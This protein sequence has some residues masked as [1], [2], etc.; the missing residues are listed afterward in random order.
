MSRLAPA[1]ASLLIAAG[2]GIQASTYYVD[3]S[4]G[5]DGQDGLKPETAW[6]SLAK[7]NRAALAPG[8][9]VLFRR[10]QTWRGQLIP[11]SGEAGAVI[12]YG[13]F[14]EGD[15]PILLGSVAANRPEDW[16]QVGQDLWATVPLRFDPIGVH[17]DLQ[18]GS[19]SFYQEGGAS[20]AFTQ[21][22]DQSG[23]ILR[24]VCQNPGTRAHHMQLSVAGLK[25]QEGE[26]YLFTFRAQATRPCTPASISLMKNGPPWTSY[27]ITQT[28]LPAIGRNWVEHTVRFYCRQTATDARLTVFLGGALPPDSTLLLRPERLLKLQSNQAI[29][30][31]V[32]V[33][34]IIFDHGAST[35]VKQWS[36]A[37]LRRDGD[38]FYD[39]RSWQVKLHSTGNPAVRHHGVEL[40]LRQHI[41]DQSGRAYVTYEHLDLRYG[42][43]HGIGGSGVHHVTIRACDISFIGGG[44]QMTQPSG[45]PVRYGNGIEFWS[46]A[47][48]CLVEGC[49]IWEIYDAALTNQGD[50]TNV[51][52][53]I[54]YRGNT[55]WSSEYSFEYWNRGSASRTRNILFE[56][57]TCV[58]AG[59][60]WGHR[61][62]PDPNGRHLMFFDNSARTTN[63]VIRDNIFS[64]ATDSL[65]WL[66]G[67]DWTSALVMDRN[68]WHQPHGSVFLWGRQTVGADE[69]MAFLR[70]RGF[71]Q[72]SVFADPKFVDPARHD[73]RLS[74]DS[75]ARAL[76]GQNNSAGASPD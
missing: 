38:Y 26:Y 33:G 62:R 34:N 14:G 24:L 28:G 5:E 23:A 58:D 73:Y 19:W 69:C 51:Q 30:L 32:D 45:K 2:P 6:R 55:I 16:Q 29:P 36:E 47:H 31:S 65:L 50:G 1:L 22:K 7:V 46:D 68:C 75:P 52:E 21:E 63:V 9:R 41:I 25:V 66:H 8:D 15:K 76:A 13:A 4:R 44:H 72:A 3:A 17:A 74:K 10:G 43:A 54:T 71:D 27:A 20:C 39:A 49:R 12:T 18:P 59:Y 57:N 53:N 11:Q 37:D 42:A 61:Q 56:H 67:R 70:S 48:D 64:T 60:G 35:G 40:A